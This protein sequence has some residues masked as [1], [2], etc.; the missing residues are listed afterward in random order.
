MKKITATFLIIFTILCCFT[1]CKKDENADLKVIDFS[2]TRTPEKTTE[3]KPDKTIKINVSADLVETLAENRDVRKFAETYGYEIT[4]KKD[5][6]I[7][8]KM[9]GKLYSLMLSNIGMD[10]MLYLGELVDSGS[11]PYLINLHDYSK[12]FSYLLFKVSTKKYNKYKD[13]LP[14]EKLAYNIGQCGLFYQNFTVEKNDSCEVIFADSKTGEVVF[15]EV[16][17]D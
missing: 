3:I 12:D 9:D 8:M 11:C 16:Y 2:T 6:T 5:G 15:R 1:A 13:K 4:E 10:I 14:Y 17:T 7:T